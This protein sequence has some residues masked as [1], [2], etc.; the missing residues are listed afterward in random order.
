MRVVGGNNVSHHPARP[1][2]AAQSCQR[3]T[4]PLHRLRVVTAAGGGGVEVGALVLLA[5]GGLVGGRALA[6]GAAALQLSR[7]RSRA[8]EAA[9]AALVVVVV[10]AAAAAGGAVVVVVMAYA[11]PT[12]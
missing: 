8:A 3:H 2:L 12:L 7:C 4:P 1:H 10:V 9:V 5:L 11:T 6:H